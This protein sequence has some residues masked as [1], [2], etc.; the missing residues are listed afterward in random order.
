MTATL[1]RKIGTA[2]RQNPRFLLL[3]AVVWVLLGLSRLAIFTLSF[4]RMSRYLGVEDG[5][6]PRTP[7]CTRDQERKSLVIKKAI[8]IASRY[9]PW[10]SNCFPQGISARAMLG[11]YT[12]PYAL[13]FGLRRDRKD[14]ELKAHA[15]VVSGRVN[16][17]G[18]SSFQQFTSV[19]CFVSQDKTTI[20]RSG[21]APKPDSFSI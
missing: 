4:K 6:D 1:L 3:V 11:F 18:G 20:N 14:N 19:G 10:K 17:S 8:G 16:V 5:L 21:N 9:T 13:F 2:F 15:W 7:I 12:I